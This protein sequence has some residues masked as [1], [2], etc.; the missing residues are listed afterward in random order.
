ML[1]P[2]V[3]MLSN[4]VGAEEVSSFYDVF[5]SFHLP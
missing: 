2:V 5:F 3:V 4:G 1:L